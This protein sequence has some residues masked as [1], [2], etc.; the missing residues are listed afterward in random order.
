M[1][2]VAWVEVT[3][4]GGRAI[5]SFAEL[6]NDQQAKRT[7]SPIYTYA[8]QPS[9]ATGIQPMLIPVCDPDCQVCDPP[10]EPP[11]DPAPAGTYT[12]RIVY[13]NQRLGAT[14]GLGNA[15]V[16]I[17]D[18]R[19]G[20][21]WLRRSDIHGRCWTLHTPLPAGELTKQ[22]PDGSVDRHRVRDRPRCRSVS[23]AAT[24]H[25]LLAR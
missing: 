25:R 19:G 5:H 13:Q 3:A 6:Y 8:S 22:S 10:P 1:G 15:M 9:A 7:P 11:P 14:V 21:R 4:S 24:R 2:G 20:A 17:F 18:M 16:A 23:H 12:G